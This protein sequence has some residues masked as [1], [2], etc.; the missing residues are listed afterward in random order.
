MS[1]SYHRCFI[2]LA[3][4]IKKEAIIKT[5]GIRSL[6]DRGTNTVMWFYHA[7]KEHRLPQLKLVK[8]VSVGDE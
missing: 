2:Q 6:Y 3:K 7:M 5:K 1:C 8:R 4:L